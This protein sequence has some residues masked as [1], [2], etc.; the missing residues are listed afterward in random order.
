MF[1][2]VD[3]GM[4]TRS[5]LERCV[6]SIINSLALGDRQ[7]LG[8]PINGSYTADHLTRTIL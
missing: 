3:V 2:G 1:D 5:L 8:I 7:N 6:D 4:E